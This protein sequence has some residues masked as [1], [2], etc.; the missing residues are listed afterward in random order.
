MLTTPQLIVVLMAAGS[1]LVVITIAVIRIAVSA[2]QLT[3]SVKA[4]QTQLQTVLTDLKAQDAKLDEVSER[5]ARLE[6]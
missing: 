4:M 5:V 2:G 6:A 1:I 3:E